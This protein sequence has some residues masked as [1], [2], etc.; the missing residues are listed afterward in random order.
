MF[1]SERRE[2]LAICPGVM[3]LVKSEADA[4]AWRV[5]REIVALFGKPLNA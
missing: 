1:P 2:H 5:G 3:L 4:E